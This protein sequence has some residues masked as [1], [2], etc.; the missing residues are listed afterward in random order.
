MYI[1]LHSC[2]WVVSFIEPVHVSDIS[3]TSG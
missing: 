3:H 1:E 2:I